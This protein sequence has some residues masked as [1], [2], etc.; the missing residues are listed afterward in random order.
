MKKIIPL[1]F[2]CSAALAQKHV[3]DTTFYASGKIQYI[4][5]VEFDKREIIYFSEQG[6]KIKKYTFI[7][8]SGDG[9]W[10]TYYRNGTK[11]M[12]T[13]Y[14]NN[15][16]EGKCFLYS[17]SGYKMGEGNYENGLLEGVFKYFYE[18]GGLLLELNYHKGLEDGVTKGYYKSGKLKVKTEIVKGKEEGEALGYYESGKKKWK[19]EHEKGHMKGEMVFYNESGSTFD[20]E[21]NFTDD[22]G[23]PELTG[24]CIKGRPDGDLKFFNEGKLVRQ[25][26]FTKGKPDGN[27]LHYDKNGTVT[28]TDV[29]KDG[30][31]VKEIKGEA[32][33][34]NNSEEESSGL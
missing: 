14:R 16:K 31:F 25:I 11:R 6:Y 7:N 4:T 22:K 5:I 9:I 18:G 10:T 3:A 12:E 21:L 20:G 33:A 8:N 32:K 15:V 19:S 13:D 1:L 24:K 23:E 30:E 29:Y 34:S 17:K 28:S 26:H 27:Y 2:L